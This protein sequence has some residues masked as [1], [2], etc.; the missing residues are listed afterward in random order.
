MKE[1]AS[2]YAGFKFSKMSVWLFRKLLKSA[3]FNDLT[4]VQDDDS[5]TL[6]NRRHSVR[7][8]NRSTAFHCTIKGLLNDLLTLFV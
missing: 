2:S 8:Y 1:F 5:A 6:L 3:V 4:L 7:D